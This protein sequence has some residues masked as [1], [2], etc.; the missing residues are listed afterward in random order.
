[1]SIRR[2]MCPNEMCGHYRVA[3]RLL[4]GCECG[5]A[6]V[7][8]LTEHEPTNE[9]LGR[10]VSMFSTSSAEVPNISAEAAAAALDRDPALRQAWLVRHG[11]LQVAL[12]GAAA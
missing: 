10:L 7:P 5:V 1:M 4:G 11:E 9:Q 8:F 12:K 2:Q 3:T 6:L